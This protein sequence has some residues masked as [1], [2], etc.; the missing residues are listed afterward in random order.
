MSKQK[1]I[2]RI[3]RHMEEIPRGYAIYKVDYYRCIQ[4]AAPIPLALP[5]RWALML[6]ERI[7]YPKRSV[8]RDFLLQIQELSG[9][10]ARYSNRI[11]EL[12]HE[13]DALR[14]R[15]AELRHQMKV[16]IGSPEELR[17]YL[18][19]AMG[20]CKRGSKNCEQIGCDCY[21]AAPIEQ[22]DFALIEH[23]V[24]LEKLKERTLSKLAEIQEKFQ[25]EA[26]RG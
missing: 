16:L 23:G 9:T 2:I 8:E 4:W 7:V 21:E 11:T 18:G 6:G 1:G 25:E 13:N 22:I 10:V 20:I 14:D 12:Q 15:N 19:E 5:L 26:D 17:E 24:D 3:L